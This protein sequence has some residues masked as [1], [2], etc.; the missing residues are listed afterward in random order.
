MTGIAAI[1]ADDRR[2]VVL[3]D[4]GTVAV[5]ARDGHVVKR[6][7]AGDDARTIALQGK[8]LAVLRSGAVD[9]YRLG[10]TQPAQAVRVPSNARSVDL[11]YRIVVVASGRDVLAVNLATNRSV[12]LFRAPS[13][14]AAQIEPPGAVVQYNI[15][16]RGYLRFVPMSAIEA[17]TA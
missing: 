12:R 13:N 15:G 7:F 5:V 6:F 1:S 3:H 2:V 9:V 11:Q 8:T 16:G 10:S 17:R 14:V 4:D